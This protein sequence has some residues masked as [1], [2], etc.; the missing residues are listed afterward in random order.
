MKD[1]KV[2]VSELSLRN[3]AK[4]STS[5][6]SRKTFKLAEIGE[7]E[8]L[9]KDFDNLH[10]HHLDADRQEVFWC[11]V[12]E[13][14]PIMSEPFYYQALRKYAT[15][16]YSMPFTQIGPWQRPVSAR[17]VV[18]ASIGRC[19]ST[20]L[21]RVTAKIGLLTWSEPDTFTNLAT[22]SAIKSQLPLYRG[23]MR[24]SLNVLS[25]KAVAA[26]QRQFCIKLRSQATFL[27]ED[28]ASHHNNTLC[29]FLVREPLAWALSFNRFWGFEADVLAR[30]LTQQVR[31]VK[32]AR[33]RGMKIHT[34]CYESMIADPIAAVSDI[35]RKC[36]LPPL[37][38]ENFDKIFLEDSQQGTSI[39]RA[40]GNKVA[41]GF[42]NS[43]ERE[44]YARA[45]ELLEKK[46]QNWFDD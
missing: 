39:S 27:I 42:S 41:S 15:R 18:V 11:K 32:E 26:N 30:N 16:G 40:S 33:A 22:S 46:P 14:A 37:S 25:D 24:L 23:L 4:K 21:S 43:F 3:K 8:L 34:L 10:I 19:G 44:L 1:N 38:A 36:N 5:I 7:G 6:S 9:V 12:P 45:P 31:Y 17:P 35:C 29:F 20:L 13:A 2:P 28:I